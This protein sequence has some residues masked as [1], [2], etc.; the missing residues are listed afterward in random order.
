MNIIKSFL[1]ALL[2]DPCAYCGKVI[3]SE[4]LMC[5]KCETELPRITGT[6]CRK[7]GREKD[8]CNCRGAEKYFSSLIAPFYFDGCV[9]KGI[10]IFKFRKGVQNYK[11]YSYEMAAAIKERYSDIY[12]DF[13]T[14]A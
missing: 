7:C 5:P 14:R 8:K 3:P 2:P 1:S 11:S 6:V 12:F 4:S 10:H 13:I 9:R